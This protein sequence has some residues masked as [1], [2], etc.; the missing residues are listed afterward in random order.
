MMMELRINLQ[1]PDLENKVF[2]RVVGK[3]MN[4]DALKQMPHTVVAH[5]IAAI[6]R[7]VID[8]SEDSIASVVITNDMLK[9]K[10]LTVP[11]LHNMA[12]DNTEKLFPLRSVNITDIL[13]DYG[14]EYPF[15][16]LDPEF[17]MPMYVL[18]NTRHINGANCL[19]YPKFLSKVAEENFQGK[20][21]N[22][23]PSSIHELI[24]IPESPEFDLKEL[25]NLV[26]EANQ[27]VVS[28]E[29]RLTDSVYKFDVDKRLVKCMG[30]DA[31]AYKPLVM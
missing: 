19:L 1:M 29:E 28:E 7:Y 24:A 20:D 16:V 2:A 5:D 22:I 21:Y 26:K 23:L 11:E 18:T 13:K 10:G 3:N 31:R 15:P 14:V 9:S 6:Y 4:M 8:V 25:L 30:S 12:V 17:G 27:T